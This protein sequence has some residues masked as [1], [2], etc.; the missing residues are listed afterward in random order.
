[1]IPLNQHSTWA[2][3]SHFLNSVEYKIR[4]DKEQML[5]YV[6]CNVLEDLVVYNKNL[7]KAADEISRIVETHVLS[8]TD[9]RI[10]R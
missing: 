9:Y 8:Y 2:E 10:G 7:K 6:T 3:I 5:Y 1:M 4:Y